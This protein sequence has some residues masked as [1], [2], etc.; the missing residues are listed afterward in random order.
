MRHAG[1]MERDGRTQAE[2]ERDRLR[3]LQHE[4]QALMKRLEYVQSE[5]SKI[6]AR[7]D[8]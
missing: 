3:H 5:M 2:I 8:R 6:P 1:W 4:E 7:P